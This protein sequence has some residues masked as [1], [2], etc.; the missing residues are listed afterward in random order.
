ML[1]LKLQMGKIAFTSATSD[2][3][4]NEITE[5][6]EE[7]SSLTGFEKR[8]LMLQCRYRLSGYNALSSRFMIE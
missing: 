4:Q 6:M 7:N 3:P 2:L 5:K 8:G 1:R